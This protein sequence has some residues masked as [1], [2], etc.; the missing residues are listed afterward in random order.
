MPKKQASFFT[1]IF[2]SHF[3]ETITVFIGFKH[4]VSIDFSFLFGHLTPEPAKILAQGFFPTH[5][6]ITCQPIE[7]ESYGKPQSR[8][9]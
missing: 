9:D 1:E 3:A 5:S 7:L 8:L 4:S 2:Q 6:T